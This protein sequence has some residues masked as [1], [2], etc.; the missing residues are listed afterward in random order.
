MQWTSTQS[1]QHIKKI[2]LK[3][4][5]KYLKINVKPKTIKVLEDNTEEHFC[6]LGLNKHFFDMT[7]KV[8][9]I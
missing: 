1:S 5:L 8:L 4:I 7:S 3:S 9:S 6:V 2:K